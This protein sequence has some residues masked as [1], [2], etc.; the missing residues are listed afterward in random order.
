MK[1][2]RMKMWLYGAVVG[3]GAYLATF[4]GL[5]WLGTSYHQIYATQISIAIVGSSFF[6]ADL[7]ASYALRTFEDVKVGDGLMLSL[8][9]VLVCS[10]IGV[11]FVEWLTDKEVPLGVATLNNALLFGSGAMLRIYSSRLGTLGGAPRLGPILW[12]FKLRVWSIIFGFAALA[13]FYNGWQRAIDM[14]EKTRGAAIMAVLVY[15][16]AFARSREDAFTQSSR[17]AIATRITRRILDGE[18]CLRP[19][20]LFARPFN[21]TGR[22]SL[23]REMRHFSTLSGYVPQEHFDL[24]SLLAKSLSPKGILIGLGDRLSEF[25]AGRVP[26][27][28]QEWKATF[29]R[30]AGAAK[31]I[32][33]IPSASP[34]TMWEIDW[35]RQSGHLSTTVFVMPPWSQEIAFDIESD[36]AKAATACEWVGIQIPAYQAGG[37]LFKIGSDGVV[38]TSAQGLALS[39]ASL[40]RKMADVL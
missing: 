13:A 21:V 25:G 26:S 24:E 40:K 34:G 4:A 19:F 38:N 20:F 32:I 10:G 18:D 1:S 17:D 28:D 29:Q 3:S 22:L 5:V 7:A 6:A 30:L 27:S 12:F 9:M 8:F 31:A 11:R 23:K 15:L 37:M 33:L 39:S 14:E 35:L 2:A 36:W 16:S